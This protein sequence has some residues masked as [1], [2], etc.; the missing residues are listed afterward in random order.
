MRR[1]IIIILILCSVGSVLLPNAKRTVRRLL[2]AIIHRVLLLRSR[3]LSLT[4]EVTLLVAP[5]QDDGTLGCGG[6][7]FQKRLSG[8]PVHVL[9][10]TDG[11]AS[12]PGHPTLTP[13]TL[14]ALRKKEARLAKSRLY[15]DSACLH[16]LDLPDGRLPHLDA[17]SRAAALNKLGALL[18]AIS[19]RTILLPWRQDGSSEHEAGFYLVTAALAEIGLRPRVLEYPVWATYRP[20]LLLQTLLTP[21]RVYHF[22]FFG[23]G[24]QKDHALSSYASQFKPVPPWTEP[25][26]PADFAASFKREEEFYFEHAP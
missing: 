13:D 22:S 6:L 3:P 4:N 21:L 2:R 19:P 14:S 12:H 8:N 10:L 11:A 5:H 25:V 23:Y 7:V 17:S 26:L 18:T 20:T 24:A 1:A 16:F 9:Y 15:L